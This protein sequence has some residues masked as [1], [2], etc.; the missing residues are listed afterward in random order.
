MQYKCL[1]CGETIHDDIG[2]VYSHLRE[3]H[4]IS[5]ERI[6]RL[7]KYVT[8]IDGTST[9]NR[10]F[11]KVGYTDDFWTKAVKKGKVVLLSY[12]TEQRCQ[13]CNTNVRRGY[14]VL[15]HK[16]FYFI[17]CNCKERVESN[18]D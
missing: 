13:R 10:S 4:G 14:A 2:C 18:T 11:V 16:G 17:C 15:L 12:N 8:H 3:Q 9:A 1:L 5:T 6:V 7:D